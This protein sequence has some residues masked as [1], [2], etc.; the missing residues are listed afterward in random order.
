MKGL[1]EEGEG[2]IAE[3]VAVVTASVSVLFKL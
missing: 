2:A 3:G 1:K